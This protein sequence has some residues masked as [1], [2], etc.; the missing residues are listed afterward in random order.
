MANKPDT[1]EIIEAEDLE[2]AD[3]LKKPDDFASAIV[4]LFSSFNLKFIIFLFI[5]FLFVSSDIFIE[6]ILNKIDGTTISGRETTTKGTIIQG[7]VLIL[8]FMG[9]DVVLKTGLI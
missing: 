8:F 4:G 5:A 9:I 1:Y 7:I 2:D 6:K 3:N